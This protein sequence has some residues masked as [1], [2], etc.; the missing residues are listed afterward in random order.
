MADMTLRDVPDDLRMWLE[1]QAEVHRRAV[2]KEVIALLEEIRVRKPPSRPRLSFDEIMEI[3]RRC[4]AL[5]TLDVRPEDDILGYDA[6]G[7]PR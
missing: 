6:H 4:A 1:Q 3:G 7:L 2:N 5:P